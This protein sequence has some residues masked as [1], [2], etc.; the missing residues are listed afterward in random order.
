MLNLI[1]R[2]LMTLGA[3]LGMVG[4]YAVKAQWIIHPHI[5]FWL[6][7]IGI[8][9]LAGCISFLCLSVGKSLSHDEIKTCM[10]IRLIDQEMI[11]PYYLYMVLAVVSPDVVSFG[12]VYFLVFVLHYKLQSQ[13][14]NP[15][16][17]F[18]GFHSYRVKTNVGT[19]IFLLAQGKV[20]R[21]PDG[22][23]IPTLRRYN[24]S[25]YIGYRRKRGADAEMDEAE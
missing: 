8:F 2:L 22:V 24:D 15:W 25:T 6:T 10:D 9:L 21:H 11:R 5:P 14:S 3:T 16:F 7:G 19:E 17:L 13:F 4:I 1:H 23:R 12:F 20:I 18:A